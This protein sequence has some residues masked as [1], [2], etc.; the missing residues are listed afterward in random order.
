[1]SRA[2]APRARREFLKLGGAGLIDLLLHPRRVLG[3]RSQTRSLSFYC[4]NTGEQLAVDY[5][6]GGRYQPDALEAIDRTLRD[7][8][9]NEL[10][11]IDPSVLDLLFMIRQ[12]LGSRERIHVVSAYRSPETNAFLHETER[13]VAAASYHVTGRAVDFFLP[14]RRLHDLRR[15]AMGLEVGG[16]GYYPRSEFVHV[17]NG[18]IRT[19]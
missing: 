1:M 5:C 14:D 16:V 9:T 15:V 4:L 19:W 18:P 3:A 10:H 8:R 2:F 13:G 17:D 6:V 12:R 11:P 7:H